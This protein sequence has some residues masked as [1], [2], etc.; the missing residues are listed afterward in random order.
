MTFPFIEIS[1]VTVSNFLLL[2]HRMKTT[3][4]LTTKTEITKTIMIMIATTD[5]PLEK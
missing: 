5:E 1:G 4:M 2:L 3:T